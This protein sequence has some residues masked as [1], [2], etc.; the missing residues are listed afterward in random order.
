[1]ST[2]LLWTGSIELGYWSKKS[3]K[4]GKDIDFYANGLK[5]WLA[6]S[7]PFSIPVALWGG[8]LDLHIMVEV[9]KVSSRWKSLRLPELPLQM[10]RDFVAGPFLEAMDLVKLAV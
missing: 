4:A 10:F 7:A 2:P 5:A 1:M 8:E 3:G 6:R 9:L